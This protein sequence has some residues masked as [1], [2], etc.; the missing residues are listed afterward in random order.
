MRN[1]EKEVSSRIDFI[2][3]MLK[4]S[5]ADGIVFGSSG[6]KDSV[7]VGILC[8]LA[9]TNTL[10]VIM[11]CESS[12]NYG[13]D[14]DDAIILAENFD[15]ETIVID[16]TKTKKEIVL[17]IDPNVN[18][19]KNGNVNI[20]PR[21]RMTTL[22]TIAASKNYLVAGTGNLSE[23]YM[24]YFTKWGDGA[25]DF[26][27]IS[28]LSVTEIFEFL[29]HLKVPNQFYTKAPSP[30]LYEGQT[31]ELEMGVSYDEID[32][33]LLNGKIG[34]NF[35]KIIKANRTT[36]HKRNPISKFRS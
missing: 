29:K 12:Q 4:N 13:Q 24:G 14:K 33:Y 35:T 32:Q 9:C 21:L 19:S 1:F 6:G 26:N 7:L 30:G 18:V 15:I 22:Y 16:L 25:C 20:A 5:G 8:K 36:E 31:D 11:P 34:Q 27:P 28:D 3:H 10:A 23:T 2:Q 17:A